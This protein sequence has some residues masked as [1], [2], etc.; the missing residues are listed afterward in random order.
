MN[1]FRK[2]MLELKDGK[3]EPF[4]NFLFEKVIKMFSNRDF[5]NFNEQTVKS[6]ILGFLT[7]NGEYMYLSEPEMNRGYADIALR[8]EARFAD[9]MYNWLLEIKYLPAKATKIAIEAKL[10]EGRNQLI[11]YLADK[12]CVSI[13]T[14]GG[15]TL[16]SAVVLFVGANSYRFEP[17]NPETSSQGARRPLSKNSGT[18]SAIVKKSVKRENRAENCLMTERRLDRNLAFQ[19]T[20]NRNEGMLKQL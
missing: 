14:E 17:F 9:I 3:I 12:K 5:I 7:L 13:M 20:I 11:K 18:P 8:R 19:C 2:T 6:L 4:I 15:V 10:E 16:K 1:N